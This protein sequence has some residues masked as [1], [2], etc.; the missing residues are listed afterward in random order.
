MTLLT[1]AGRWST[2]ASNLRAV[3]EDD[4][5][6]LPD[7]AC[8]ALYVLTDGNIQII[9]ESDEDDEPQ[10]LPVKAAQVVP[11][12]VRRVMTGTTATVVAMY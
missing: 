5:E 1:S 11:I 2:P 6:D 9:A 10:T 12:R 7:G 8:K 4:Y 3:E